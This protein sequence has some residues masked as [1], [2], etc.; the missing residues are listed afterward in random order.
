MDPIPDDG[1]K[2]AVTNTMWTHALPFI[3]WLVCL[4]L[5]PATGWAY[6]LRTVLGLAV[7]VWCCP[8]RWYARFNRRHIVSSLIVGAVVAV[9]WIVPESRW[10]N[11]HIPFLSTAYQY[12]GIVPPWSTPE[13]ITET[14]YAPSVCGWWFTLARLMGS[15]IAVGCIEEFF[16]RGFIYRWLV[17]N[18]FLKVNMGAYHPLWFWV[19]ALMFGLEHDRWLVGILAGAIYGWYAIKTR[20]IW[21][22]SIAHGITNLLLGIYVIETE[23]WF[24]W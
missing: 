4:T 6:T 16:W 19:T 22:V 17:Q 7:F 8:W 5:L 15:A 11:E 24:F 2:V 3:V 14:P 1:D 23:A 21:A 9:V 12:G 20:D 13:A 18:N 10:L